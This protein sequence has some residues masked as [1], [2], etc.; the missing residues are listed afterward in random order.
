MGFGSVAKTEDGKNGSWKGRRCRDFESGVESPSCLL[1]E[2]RQGGGAEG[3]CTGGIWGKG[4][5]G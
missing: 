1:R 2:K 5:K 3:A 4:R